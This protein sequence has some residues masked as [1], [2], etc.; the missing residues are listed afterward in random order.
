MHDILDV[1]R[2]VKDLYENNTNLAM[3]KDIERVIDELDIY[4]Y[5]NWEDGEVAYGPK[6]DRH[7]VTVGFMWPRDK[8]PD[9]EGGKRLIDLGCK[10]SYE[11]SYLLEP[12]KIRTPDDF[13]PETKK[14]KLDRRP[15]WI[16]EI[17]MPKK[18]AFDM[19]RGYMEKLRSDI[20][21]SSAPKEG[22]TPQGQPAPTTPAA[23][24]PAAAP[25]AGAG[26]PPVAP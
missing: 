25:A 17:Q 19:Y 14:G 21:Y 18:I 13:R 6:V 4:V 8:M 11:K 24:T 7:W 15:I 5:K 20:E 10:V 3:L 23:T 1:I 12:R 26:T 2:N 9:P 16:V 22:T